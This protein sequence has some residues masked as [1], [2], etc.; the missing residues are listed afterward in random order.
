MMQRQDRADAAE[1]RPQ[2]PVS[3]GKIEAFK[4]CPDDGLL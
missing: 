2:G 4:P 3:A 1:K